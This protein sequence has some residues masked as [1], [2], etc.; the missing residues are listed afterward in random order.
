MPIIGRIY[1]IVSSEC[2]GV[3]IGST[4]KQ[5][6]MRFSC[7][8]SLYK[9]YVNGKTNYVT[10]F[11]IMKFVDAKIELI[12]EGMFEGKKDLE[13][14]EGETMRTTP[15][16]VN[17]NV[18][19]ARDRDDIQKYQEQYRKANRE[20]LRTYRSTK[21]TCAICGGKYTIS[22]K[23]EHIRSKKHQKASSSTEPSCTSSDDEG[24]TETDISD[25]EFDQ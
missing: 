9:L 16:V 23:S 3:Y 17:K 10:S 22:H 8:K 6:E 19:G 15:N 12:H 14:F 5:L 25:P 20:A 4:T 2:D 21:C 13:K 7:H 11:E 18:A 1:K 24:D